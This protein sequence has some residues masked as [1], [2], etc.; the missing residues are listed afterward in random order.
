M[1][2]L[3]FSHCPWGLPSKN[4]IPKHS[5]L[6]Y[7]IFILQIEIKRGSFTVAAKEPLS[8]IYFIFSSGKVTRQL[9]LVS[10]SQV[11]K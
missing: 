2:L 9:P 10:V 4:I 7:F 1:H 5:N 6:L 3:L 11:T 8:A